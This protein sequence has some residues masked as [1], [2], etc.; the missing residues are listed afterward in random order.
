VALL[1]GIII[2]NDD[3]DFI[4]EQGLD[5]FYNYLMSSDRKI[6]LWKH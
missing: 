6:E 2:N 1:S 3:V 4:K 5:N